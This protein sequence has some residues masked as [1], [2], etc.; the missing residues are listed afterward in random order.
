MSKSQSVEIP[1]IDPSQ[2]VILLRSG[3]LWNSAPPRYDPEGNRQS[4]DLIDLLND[5][6]VGLA[7]DNHVN[8]QFLA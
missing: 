8:S 5:V 7:R 1:G 4:I 6:K 3:I 2:S